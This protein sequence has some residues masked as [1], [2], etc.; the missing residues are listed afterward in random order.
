MTCD[1]RRAVAKRQKNRQRTEFWTKF[2]REVG[3]PLFLEKP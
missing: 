2:Q 1:N 3:L